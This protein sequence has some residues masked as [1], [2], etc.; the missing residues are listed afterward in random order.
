MRQSKFFVYNSIRIWILSYLLFFYQ[1]WNH[2][3]TKDTNKHLVKRSCSKTFIMEPIRFNMRCC[4]SKLPLTNSIG[5]YF[6]VLWV[7]DT[8]STLILLIFYTLTKN[9]LHAKGKY[10]FSCVTWE[11]FLNI[12]IFPKRSIHIPSPFFTYRFSLT[13][14][15]F[16]INI[17]KCLERV[18]DTVWWFLFSTDN[19]ETNSLTVYVCLYVPKPPKLLNRLVW[20]R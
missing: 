9:K 13:L 19:D 6:H 15:N 4:V 8:S 5:L 12:F 16:T 17:W 20:M 7:L 11:G 10:I 1:Y 3:N 18:L 2:Y 14:H